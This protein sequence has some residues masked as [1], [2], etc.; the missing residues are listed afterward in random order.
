MPSQTCRVWCGVSRFR[1]EHV[2]LAGGRQPLRSRQHLFFGLGA[3]GTAD[4]QGPFVPGLLNRVFAVS[5]IVC[6]V[7]IDL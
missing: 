2:H 6:I 5:S 3:A 7:I 1:P 4:D